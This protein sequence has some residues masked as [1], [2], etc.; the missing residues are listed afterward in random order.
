MMSQEVLR[1]ADARLS[2]Q[3]QQV[4]SGDDDLGSGEMTFQLADG[5]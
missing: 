2:V 4:L 5:L 3:V 1:K